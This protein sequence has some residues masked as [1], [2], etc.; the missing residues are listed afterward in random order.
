MAVVANAWV[1]FRCQV[2]FL[3]NARF[4]TVVFVLYLC[5]VC[6]GSFERFHKVLS[7]ASPL[8][9]FRLPFWVY[10]SNTTRFLYFIYSSG[11]SKD[12]CAKEI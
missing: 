6:F 12:H 8:A 7:P 2:G 9:P 3:V 4:I 5:V 1:S 11:V 10:L